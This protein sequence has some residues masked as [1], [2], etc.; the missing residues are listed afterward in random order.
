MRKCV[1]MGAT[2]IFLP[3]L[4]INSHEKLKK[5]LYK[6][7]ITYNNDII[8]SSG[9]KNRRGAHTDAFTHSII[10]YFYPNRP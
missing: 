9:K 1:G 4:Y 10:V 2:P 8:Y 5:N 6:F 3:V 7:H